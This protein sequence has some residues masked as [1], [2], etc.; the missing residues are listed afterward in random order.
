MQMPK[1]IFI[2]ITLLSM[3]KYYPCFLVLL[4]SYGYILNL[5]RSIF[6]DLNIIMTMQKLFTTQPCNK[7]QFFAVQ[8]F[9]KL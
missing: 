1:A 2:D 8:L 5:V 7:P 4:S 9:L 6:S 3:I